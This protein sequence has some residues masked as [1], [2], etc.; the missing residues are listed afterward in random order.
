[1]SGRISGLLVLLALAATV[2]LGTAQP[3]PNAN[4]PADAVSPL[5]ASITVLENVKLT[6]EDGKQVTVSIP[7]CIDGTTV[8]PLPVWVL[9]GEPEVSLEGKW[10][11]RVPVQCNHP[12]ALLGTRS[13]SSTVN[14]P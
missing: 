7:Y 12:P 8:I 13:V 6:L 9:L 10:Q 11:A 4:Q 2:T 3:P 5:V 1:M 14:F